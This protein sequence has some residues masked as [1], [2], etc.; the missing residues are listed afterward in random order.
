MSK[1]D[2]IRDKEFEENLDEQKIVYYD[3]TPS[4]GAYAKDLDGQ[5]I[6]YYDNT[7]DFDSTPS[8]VLAEK[9]FDLL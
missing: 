8:T 4:T 6:V 1:I 3:N 5:K 2:V 9:N 7:L